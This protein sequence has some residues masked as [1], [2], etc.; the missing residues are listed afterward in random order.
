MCDTN[1][2]GDVH[3]KTVGHVHNFCKIGVF[4]QLIHWTQSLFLIYNLYRRDYSVEAKL[5]IF[6][7]LQ[8]RFVFSLRKFLFIMISYYTTKRLM[9]CHHLAVSYRP[10]NSQIWLAAARNKYVLLY[11]HS[12]IGNVLLST[13]A[14]Q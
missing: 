6:M 7:I 13:R 10:H 12:A 4:N 5:L 1:F 2:N 8:K 14:L 9:Y 3:S 11:G